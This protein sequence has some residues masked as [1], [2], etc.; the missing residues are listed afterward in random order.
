[1]RKIF[2]SL[3]HSLKQLI[4]LK[5]LNL[6]LL[7]FVNLGYSFKIVSFKFSISFILYSPI[8]NPFTAGV[9]NR[10]FN[11]WIFQS[12]FRP[13]RQWSG[14][15]IKRINPIPIRNILVIL[16]FHPFPSV[17]IVGAFIIKTHILKFNVPGWCRWTSP[18]FHRFIAMR[19]S[20][21]FFLI[22]TI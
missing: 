3:Q 9:S 22:H 1:M 4:F 7:S 12:I 2:T 21:N 19:A 13:N 16:F 18:F 15:I 20:F 6:N 14:L 11:Y 17:Y 5:Q 8:L 10:L